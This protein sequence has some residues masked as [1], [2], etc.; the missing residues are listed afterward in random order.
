MKLCVEPES[1]RAVTVQPLIRASSCIVLL[2]LIPVRA[3]LNW[4]REIIKLPRVDV[5]F[6]RRHDV[7]LRKRASEVLGH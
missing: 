1:K 4:G 6:V 2:E 3:N 7:P 5:A